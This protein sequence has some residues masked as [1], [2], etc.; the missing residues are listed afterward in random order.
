MNCPTVSFEWKPPTAGKSEVECEVEVISIE[1]YDSDW[2]YDP[3]SGKSSAYETLNVYPEVFLDVEMIIR[4]Q[5][6]VSWTIAEV[7]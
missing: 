7:W 6:L 5:K 1:K 3:I 4:D 2:E